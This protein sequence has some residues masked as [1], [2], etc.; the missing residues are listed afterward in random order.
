MYLKCV[1]PH[2]HCCP[3][4]ERFTFLTLCLFSFFSIFRF[5]FSTVT[6]GEFKDCFSEYVASTAGTEGG[7]SAEA[8]KTVQGLDWEDLFLS[9][10]ECAVYNWM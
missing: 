9:K 2:H 5:K 7:V 10:G 4:S 8:L 1:C 3:I 6:S